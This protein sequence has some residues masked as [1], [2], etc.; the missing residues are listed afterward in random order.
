M[1]Y[2]KPHGHKPNGLFIYIHDLDDFDPKPSD[3]AGGT[4]KIN[5]T[6]YTEW[7][8]EFEQALLWEIINNK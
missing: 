1:I 2:Y 5:G 8:D 3:F 6:I 7:N 4:F